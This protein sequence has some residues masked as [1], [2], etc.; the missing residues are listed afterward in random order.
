MKLTGERVLEGVIAA[1]AEQVAPQVDD[2][3]AAEALRMAGSLVAIVGRA[4]DDAAAIRVAE[5]AGMRAL[6]AR[7]SDVVGEPGLAARLAEA[8]ASTD[9]GLRIGELDGETGRLRAL[10]IEL[11][12]W[13]ETRDSPEARDLD[14][15]IW[16]A[17]REWEM[18]RAPRG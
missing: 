14:G 15:A 9:P 18:A 17:M 4:G 12:N 7:A 10:L 13:L 2:A 11:H 6:F 3:F 16:R 5:N 8:A 1:L